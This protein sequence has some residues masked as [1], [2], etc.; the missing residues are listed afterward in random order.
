MGQLQPTDLPALHALATTLAGSPTLP[1]HIRDAGDFMAIALT[2]VELGMTV[3]QAVR[4]MH[5]V[6]GRVVL[7]AE[8]HLALLLSR[9]VRLRWL[10]TTDRVARIRLERD[11]HEPH[12][13]TYTWEM[14]DRAGLTG[15]KNW[16]AHPEAMLRARCASAAARAYAPDLLMGVYV[17][18]ELD[19]S[20]PRDPP[21][22][23]EQVIDAEV[24]PPAPQKWSRQEQARFFAQ[25]TEAWPDER[26]GYDGLKRFCGFIGRPKPSLMTE[27]QRDG[28]LK[29]LATAAGESRVE[30]WLTAEGKALDEDAARQGEGGGDGK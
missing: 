19:D 7:S 10:E 11:G 4:S 30:D 18:G 17:E 26:D 16:R 12:E 21:P 24:V 25:L 15:R 5:L 2:G 23:R 8:A 1:K 13:H 27:A 9:G 29:W 3:M 6:E 22:Q 20:E 28:L 14:A